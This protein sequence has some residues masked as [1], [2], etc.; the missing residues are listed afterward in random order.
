MKK[1]LC[2][3]LLMCVLPLTIASC[4]ASNSKETYTLKDEDYLVI[5]YS[6]DKVDEFYANKYYCRHINQYWVN[7]EFKTKITYWS[8]GL[9][10]EVKDTS[11]STTTLFSYRG[12]ISYQLV[13]F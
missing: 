1:K 5:R 10:V 13:K 9:D 2:L 6:D 8:S 12:D 3:A 4:N 11:L 7:G